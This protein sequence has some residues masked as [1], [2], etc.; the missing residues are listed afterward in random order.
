MHALTQTNLA[1]CF[2]DAQYIIDG[3]FP[4]FVPHIPSTSFV[5]Y[6]SRSI[7]IKNKFKNHTTSHHITPHRLS[8][9]SCLGL[10]CPFLC[11]HRV[12]SLSPSV[13]FIGYV[14]RRWLCFAWS[15]FC[16]LWRSRLRRDWSSFRH[17]CRCRYRFRRITRFLFAM[18]TRIERTLRK[19][20]ARQARMG[21]IRKGCAS[22]ADRLARISRIGGLCIIKAHE[23]AFN[24]I[25][26]LLVVAF[27]VG[28]MHKNVDAFF[29]LAT[30]ILDRNKPIPQRSVE[31]L[32]SSHSL[33]NIGSRYRCV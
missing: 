3:M 7:S 33:L 22:H 15:S 9:R 14:A 8:R 19:Q 27:N 23:L 24:K 1:C 20:V 17:G 30:Y 4:A 5:V 18:M 13:T 11:G 28:V 16:I 12:P 2:I 32:D 21:S 26:V 29:V 10:L 6:G 25:R 31:P